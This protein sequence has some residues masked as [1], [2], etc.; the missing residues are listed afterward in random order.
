ML[1][2]LRGTEREREWEGERGG[3]EGKAREKGRE[4]GRGRERARLCISKDKRDTAYNVRGE[5]V[6]VY[7]YVGEYSSALIAR[8]LATPRRKR[9][10]QA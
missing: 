6:Y 4:R 1:A 8:S 7:K 9:I 3:G 10:L 2:S 5:G